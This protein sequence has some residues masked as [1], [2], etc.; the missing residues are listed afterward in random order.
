LFSQ[1]KSYNDEQERKRQNKT[2]EMNAKKL[3]GGIEGNISN[4]IDNIDLVIASNTQ[5]TQDHNNNN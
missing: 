1:K 4:E 5:V 2:K 3:L